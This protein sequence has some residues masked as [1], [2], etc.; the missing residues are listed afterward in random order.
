MFALSFKQLATALFFCLSLFALAP[1]A[2]AQIAYVDME[3]IIENMPDYKRV[4]SELESYQK[5]L[6]K[7]L[8]AEEKKMQDYYTSVM[9]QAQAGTMSPAQQKEAEAKLQKMQEDLQKKAADA[10]KQLVDKEAALSKPLYDKL[11]G[12]IK[13]VATAN[14]YAYIVDKKLLLYSD[15]GIDATG[16]LKSQ[17]GIP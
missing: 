3:Q 16:K 12:A 8:Q 14:K 9:Q 11:N 7:Q 17:L 2:D 4:K 1:Q 5:V 6:E 13:S 10:E 15:G